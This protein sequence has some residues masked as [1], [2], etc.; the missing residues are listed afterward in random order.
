MQS[1]CGY[2]EDMLLKPY[3]AQFGSW[4]RSRSDH[5]V[6]ECDCCVNICTNGLYQGERKPDFSFHRLNSTSMK[7]PQKEQEK[8]LSHYVFSSCP[9]CG[10]I[11][12]VA[13]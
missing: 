1:I 13:T 8:H 5:T 3:H 12:E 4:V 6:L 7:T 10:R 11:A 2:V 9:V